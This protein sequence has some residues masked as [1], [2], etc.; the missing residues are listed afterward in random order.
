MKRTSIYLEEEELKLLKHLAVEEEASLAEL[1]RRAVRWYLATAAG[2]IRPAPRV[3]SDQ[4]WSKRLDE[5]L[6]AIRSRLP[7]V[8]P[9]KIEADIT[10]AREEAREARRQ[11]DAQKSRR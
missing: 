7:A 2:R 8:L 6:A 4:E 9:E 5:L 3:L 11:R 10:I 1:V